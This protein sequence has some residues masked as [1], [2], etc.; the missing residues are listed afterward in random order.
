M[1]FLGMVCGGCRMTDATYYA[2]PMPAFENGY[3]ALLA[4]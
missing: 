1:A 4:I 2:I 3:Y